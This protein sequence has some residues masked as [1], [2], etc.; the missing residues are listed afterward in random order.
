[1]PQFKATHGWFYNAQELEKLNG[2]DGVVGTG[3]TA[4]QGVVAPQV[5]TITVPASTSITMTDATT[6]GSHGS[7]KIFTLPEGNIMFLGAVTNLTIARVGIALTATAPIVAA[8]G[9]TAV[10]TDNATLLTTEANIMASTSATLA[11]GV[12]A[13]NGHSTSTVK[14]DGTTT[15]VDLYL[16]F[17]VADAGS[18][19]NDALTVSGTI[20]V[21]YINLGDN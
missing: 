10:A 15:P 7:K 18:T 14:L 5:T 17:A 19:G 16:N 21:T 11:A 20:T 9:S 1:M 2:K 13:V 3:L 4:V 6:N 12:G 8:I